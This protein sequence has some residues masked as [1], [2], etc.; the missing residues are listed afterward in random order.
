MAQLTGV[1]P[2]LNGLEV[3]R[4]ILSAT[5]AFKLVPSMGLEPPISSLTFL[6]KWC[7][8]RDSNPQRIKVEVF[9][10]SASRQFRHFGIIIKSNF[11]DQFIQQD[12][13]YHCFLFCYC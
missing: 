12:I 1:E 13:L 4:I 11:K 10:T 5:A 7:R 2:A 8:R 3:R 6:V 9:E